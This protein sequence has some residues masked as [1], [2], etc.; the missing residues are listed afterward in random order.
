MFEGKP[1]YAEIH[2]M[3][4]IFMIPTKPAPSFRDTNKCSKVFLEFTSKCLVKRT[5]DRASASELLAHEFIKSSESADQTLRELIEQ[6]IQIKADLS[7]NQPENIL[8]FAAAANG[9]GKAKENANESVDATTISNYE[10]LIDNTRKVNN[11]DDMTMRSTDTFH[12]MATMVI[13]DEKQSNSSLK[14]VLSNE[15]EEGS[16]ISNEEEA[17]R[18]RACIQ[19]EVRLWETDKN[20]LNGLCKDE[21]RLRLKYLDE[22]ME[23]EIDDLKLKYERKRNI[24]LDVI[25]MKKKNAQ[26]Y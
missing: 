19:K 21:I 14:P 2:P 1:P 12:S 23:H 10:T 13:N 3:R 16:L 22:Q 25:E 7:A 20:I 5:S 6:V 9:S 11:D 18:I 26:I 4:A 24:I 8:N 17:K 15:S